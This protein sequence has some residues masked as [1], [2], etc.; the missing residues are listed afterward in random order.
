MHQTLQL[1]LA[2][3][4]AL[5]ERNLRTHILQKLRLREDDTTLIRKTRQSVDARGRQVRVNVQA[6]VY[7]NEQPP[8]LLGHQTDYPDVSKSPSAIIVGCGPA[9][10]FAALRLIELGIRPVIFERGKDV[11]AR[12]RD[13]AAINK[14]HIVNPESNYCF[15]EGGAGTYS[16]GKLYTRSN[17]RGDI[18]RV[19][20]IFVRH[21]A[22]EQILIDSHPHIG[23][24]KL[25]VVVSEM[26]E[27]ILKAGGEIHF[28]TKVTDLIIETGT[29]TGVITGSGQEH[30]GIGVIL[31]T[32]HSARDIYYLLHRKNI[33]IESKSFA[34]GV[35]IEHPQRVI[36]QIQYHCNT[37]R[38]P[39]LPAASY[40]L[41]TQTMYKGVRRGVFSF[42]MCP[43]GFIVPA[44]TVPGEVVVN[45]MSPSRRDSPY[46]NSGM[47]ATVEDEDIQ[48]YKKEWGPLAGLMFQQE[49]EQK[50]WKMA[51]QTQ[52]AP[53]QL[54][55]DFVKSKISTNLRDTSYQPGL[56]SVDLYDILPDTIA[57]PLR[58]ALTDFGK[59]MRGYLSPEAQLIGVES[60]TSSPVRIPRDRDTC[61]HPEIKGL[62]PCGEGAGYAGGIMSAAMDG[63]RCAE[64][65]AVHCRK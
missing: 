17:K 43:G 7:V 31:A 65:L 52:T 15:G 14:D 33:L 28:D 23:T 19:L 42:C 63:E 58:D 41:V 34:M 57:F 5:D 20:E 6:E 4:I 12:R 22:T 27:S 51:G 48:P 44:A 21:G 1:V 36:D 45:G 26:R 49:M 56:H 62:F 54:A 29:I 53:A 61:E 60:R 10:M 2:P 16:D 25:P 9:G 18:R 35:R 59:K 39:Y 46:A 8:A 38:G 37:D 30:R 11:R 55:S 64:Q 40:S 3:E 24:N 47:V 50:A 32:G 13:L